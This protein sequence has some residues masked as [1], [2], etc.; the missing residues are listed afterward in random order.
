MRW[1]TPAPA[2]GV[3]SAC[4]RGCAWHPHD[5]SWPRRWASWTPT[6][7]CPSTSPGEPRCCRLVDGGAA[8]QALLPPGLCS[9]C[10]PLHATEAPMFFLPLTCPSRLSSAPP[11]R[12]QARAGRRAG[13]PQ[14]CAAAELDAPRHHQRHRGRRLHLW[15]PPG[16]QRQ[17][18]AGILEPGPVQLHPAL[19]LLQGCHPAHPPGLHTRVSGRP[20]A[21]N[22]RARL[23]CPPDPARRCAD[24]SRAVVRGAV[25]RCCPMLSRA[26]PRPCTAAGTGMTTSAA[27]C[28][29]PA[30]PLTAP[31]RP[32]VRTTTAQAPTPPCSRRRATRRSS[33]YGGRGAACTAAC[34][35]VVVM[36][37]RVGV[38]VLGACAG[39][40]AASSGSGSARLAA[41][42]QLLTPA[43]ACLPRPSQMEKVC[44][45][46]GV[47]DNLHWTLNTTVGRQ[48]CAAA[49]LACWPARWPADGVLGSRSFTCRT[50]SLSLVNGPPC[51]PT[52]PRSP[53][54]PPLQAAVRF[55]CRGAVRPARLLHVQDPVR[56]VP[57]PCEVRQ[58]HPVHAGALVWWGWPAGGVWVRVAGA[59]GDYGQAVI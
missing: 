54:R 4:R 17:L 47:P 44:N 50:G 36:C 45:L 10:A 41:R 1:P 39:P 5:C 37:A 24:L 57:G 26:V 28:T 48:A 40:A 34:V 15:L 58:P 56:H 59:L 31:R 55:C 7:P 27:L 46:E 6:A 13:H 32:A 16:G 43:A 21:A 53:P 29:C 19:R 14:R 12:P 20:G 33:R 23:A 51:S 8:R 30:A 9:C 11:P 49:G 35:L 22:S 38:V 18:G 52:C 42:R 25:L 3:R 2:W